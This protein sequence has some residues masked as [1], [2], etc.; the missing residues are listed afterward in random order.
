MVRV[1]RPDFVDRVYLR[2]VARGRVALR[3]DIFRPAGRQGALETGR[4]TPMSTEIGPLGQC[5]TAKR[6]WPSEAEAQ[7]SLDA[8]TATSAGSGT[9]RDSPSAKQPKRTGKPPKGNLVIGA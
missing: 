2:H 5:V 9:K 6:S 1:S 4:G 8:T 7:A 3:P